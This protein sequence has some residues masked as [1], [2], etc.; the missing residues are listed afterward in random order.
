MIEIKI[1]CCS[2][3]KAIHVFIYFFKFNMTLLQDKLISP[4]CDNFEMDQ[5][6]MKIQ[7]SQIHKLMQFVDPE[8]CSYLGK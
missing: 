1:F 4:Q 6:G 5:A 2:H 8:L 7:L 3:V